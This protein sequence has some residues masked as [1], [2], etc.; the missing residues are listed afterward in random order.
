MFFNGLDRFQDNIAVID[1]V[2]GERITYMDLEHQA[3][4]LSVQLGNNK[5]LVF[6]ES[7][8]S[9]LSV[10]SYVAC[11]RSNKVVYL[12]DNFSSD[13]SI[14]LINR[15]NPNLLIN[16]FGKI[17]QHSQ[18]TYQLH[19]DLTLLLSTS[20]TTGTPK[21]VKLS[22][23]NI[24]SNTESIVEYLNLT[25]NDIA[26][27][28]LKLH[29][30]YGLSVLHSHLQAGACTV[31]T[32]HGVL[33][34]SFWH[35]LVTYSA[36]S[37]AGV[38]YT[39]EA[40]LK[41]K[42]DF[43]AYPSLRYITQAGGKL[44]GFL[45]KEYAL[46]AQ[47]NGIDFFVMYGQTEASPR[48]S[49]LPPH[50]AIDFPNSIGRAIPQGELSIVDDEGHEIKALDKSGELVYRGKNVMMG[51][52][53]SIAGLAEDETP[54][55][56]FTGDIACRTQ[57]DLF[58]L[59]GRTKRFVKLFGLRINLDD[60]QSVV[61]TDYPQSAVTGNDKA[62]VIALES[63]HGDI[64]KGQ[65]LTRLS[66]YYS[67]PRD[68]FIITLFDD[69]PLLSNGK[70]DFM[71]IANHAYKKPSVGFFKRTLCSI[72]NILELNEREWESISHLFIDALNLTEL[73]PDKTF[74]SLNADSLSFVY[75]SVELEQ[76]LGCELPPH[77]QQ[78]SVAELDEIYTHVR[79]NE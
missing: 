5:E 24:Q 39:F 78:C 6:I 60:V 66:D 10:V 70:Y 55:V 41:T 32:A 75:L 37:F 11:L 63:S 8:N 43:K 76:C 17:T 44:E 25:E 72:S 45:V 33:D 35:D 22:A 77:W 54:E 57:H 21:F 62:I 38:P 65:L 13:K 50:L 16:G 79:F 2:S 51:Y 7:K 12:M 9:I 26:L 48:I 40:L 46:Q 74:H 47:A 59:V 68:K 4:V 28:H 18:C 15:Y 1:A 30:A 58:Y 69:I 56:L 3:N 23:T 27:A 61:K 36:T 53:N 20:G 52:A 64:D 42:F 67:L 73:S 34:A 71:T 19:P 14:E 29:Y 49:Y 31:F